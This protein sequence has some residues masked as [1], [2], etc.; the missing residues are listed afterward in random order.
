MGLTVALLVLAGIVIGAIA[1]IRRF[2]GKR[3]TAADGGDVLAYLLLALSVGVAGFALASLA[4]TAF[5][6]EDFVI[7]VSGRVA[8]SLAAIVV[9]TPV[10]VFLWRRQ[11]RRRAAHPASAGW[12]VYLSL[13]EAVF[14]TSLAAALFGFFEWLLTDAAGAGWT[15]IVVF[16]GIVVFH[17]WAMR[18]TP[19]ASDGA[20]LPR[21]VGSAIGLVATAIGIGGMVTWLLEELYATLVATAGGSDL[22][23][24]ASFLL[25]GGP[26][27]WYRWLRPWPGEPDTPRN[28]WMFLVSVAGLSTAIGALTFTAVE[29]MTYL[30]TET[31]PAGSHFDFLPVTLAT[32]LVAA[33]AWAHHRRRL[34]RERTDP[35]RAY[36]YAMSAIGL[37]TSVGAATALSTAAF[38]PPSIVT[39][40]NDFVILSATGAIVAAMVWFWFWMKASR[41]PREIEAGSG[42]RRF[43]LVGMSVV[44]GLTSA[45]ALIAA[46]VIV[47]RQLLGTTGTESIALPVSLFVFAGLATWHLL[48]VNADDRELVGSRETLT[49][50][51]VTIVCSH[52]G[53]ISTRFP[54]VAKIRVL[55]RDD[56]SG[57]IDEEMA[58]AIVEAVGNRDSYVWVDAEGY[59]IAP[60]R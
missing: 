35:V 46:L 2:V 40:S 20:G 28:F 57:V 16:G 3:D 58:D 32:A 7:D 50:F 17:E 29:T 47:F 19:P 42:P 18:A 8:N 36:D 38:G 21:V 13:I 56:D 22:G 37:A 27:W 45:G 9:A 60:A 54:D 25:A 34:G 55:Y 52:P 59:R 33:S 12:T 30:F 49:P 48:R 26:I 11:A 43:Y 39:R 14:M 23:T 53:M 41:Q 31:P 24:W 4:A 15:N 6:D 10:A 44:L 5:P 51:S 1:V